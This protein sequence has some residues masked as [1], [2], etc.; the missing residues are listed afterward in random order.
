MHTLCNGLHSTSLQSS[1]PGNE[2]DSQPLASILQ[3]QLY[4]TVLFYYLLSKKSLKFSFLSIFLY[5]CI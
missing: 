1:Y 2:S 4:F 3:G 5:Y